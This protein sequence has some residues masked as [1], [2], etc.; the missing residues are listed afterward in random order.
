MFYDNKIVQLKAK[1]TKWFK[2]LK[3]LENQVGKL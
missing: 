3:K 2:A 1:V